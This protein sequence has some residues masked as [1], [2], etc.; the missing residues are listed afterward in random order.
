MSS[1]TVCSCGS[2]CA[3][4]WIPKPGFCREPIA[5]W[6]A[7]CFWMLPCRC[8]SYAPGPTSVPVSTAAVAEPLKRSPLPAR[9]GAALATFFIDFSSSVTPMSVALSSDVANLFGLCA[10]GPGKLVCT[11]LGRCGDLERK[12]DDVVGALLFLLVLEALLPRLVE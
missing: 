12:L 3:A 1:S 10:P 5:T 2:L 9:C 6:L 7:T 8:A 11:S 4:A